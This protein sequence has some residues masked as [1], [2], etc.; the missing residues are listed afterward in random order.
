I[1]ERSEV[2]HA[3][4]HAE[5][6][7][8]PVHGSGGEMLN[9]DIHAGSVLLDAE[10]SGSDAHLMRRIAVADLLKRMIEIVAHELQDVDV[11]VSLL[12]DFE[13]IMVAR[14]PGSEDVVVAVLREPG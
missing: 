6:Q 5:Q 4:D 3:R 2:T 13:G 10:R 11:L 7:C 1:A 14:Q 12:E 9:P 8:K